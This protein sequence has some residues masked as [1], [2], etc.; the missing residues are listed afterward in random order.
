LDLILS[1]H[2][3]YLPA[4]QLNN[5]HAGGGGKIFTKPPSFS[6]SVLLLR[7]LGQIACEDQHQSAGCWSIKEIVKISWYYFG[8][9]S[10]EKLFLVL[11]FQI[12]LNNSNKRDLSRS[13]RTI[14]KITN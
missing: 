10:S 1:E 9:F 14:P 3:S 11:L 13:L 7:L 12:S 8:T 6:S 4:T 5:H 2:A